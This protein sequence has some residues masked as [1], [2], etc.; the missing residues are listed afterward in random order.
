[1]TPLDHKHVPAIPAEYGNAVGD[2]THPA[3]IGG[4]SHAIRRVLVGDDH[5]VV[6]ETHVRRPAGLA[7]CQTRDETREHERRP[8]S[9]P[10]IMQHRH[11]HLAHAFEPLDVALLSVFVYLLEQLD[12]LRLE[13]R[14]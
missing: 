14:L 5:L 9:D 1:L 7:A 3:G 8:H 10:R 2:S 11:E 4:I 12:R 6:T 13:A